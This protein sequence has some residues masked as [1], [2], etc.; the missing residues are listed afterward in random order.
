[1]QVLQRK[2]SQKEGPKRLEKMMSLHHQFL[3]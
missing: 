3:N 1:L 2:K